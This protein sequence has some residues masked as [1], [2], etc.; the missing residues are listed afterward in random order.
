MRCV[1]YMLAS[2]VQGGQGPVRG[3]A[4]AEAWSPEQAVGSTRHLP[5]S[6]PDLPKRAYSP[7]RQSQ[8]KRYCLARVSSK[9]RRL[10]ALIAREARKPI[11]P[12]GD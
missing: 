12:N 2:I 11:G 10:R 7:R 5:L 8:K 3:Q 4:S 6:S 9:K 1:V